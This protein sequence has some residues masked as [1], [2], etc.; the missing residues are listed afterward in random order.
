MNEVM[1]E[2]CTEQMKHIQEAQHTIRIN[3]KECTNRLSEGNILQLSPLKK[4]Q[5]SSNKYP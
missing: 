1:K 5:P 2:E 4:W 3:K